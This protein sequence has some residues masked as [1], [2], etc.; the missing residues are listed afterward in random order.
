MTSVG[1]ITKKIHIFN[2]INS[3]YLHIHTRM[4]ASAHARTHE[5]AIPPR[6]HTHTTCKHAQSLL[7]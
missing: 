4:H 3:Q 1:S 6:K 7:L 2:F 5:H